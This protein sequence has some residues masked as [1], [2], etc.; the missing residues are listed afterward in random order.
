MNFF[1]TD[2]INEYKRIKIMHLAFEQVQHKA[3][4]YKNIL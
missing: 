4:Y 3:F 2:I 1:Q